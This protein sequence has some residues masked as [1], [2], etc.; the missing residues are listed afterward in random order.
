MGTVTLSPK[1]QVVIPKEA[2]EKVHLKKGQK[3]VVIVKGGIISLIPERPLKEL[4]GFAKGI[5]REGLRD[6]RDRL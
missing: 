2:R 4:R 3:I 6:K 5:S 1:Y